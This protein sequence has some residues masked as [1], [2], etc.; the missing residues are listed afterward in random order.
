MFNSE[1]YAG[2]R[3]AIMEDI[4]RHNRVIE[5][6]RLSTSKACIKRFKASTK[7]LTRLYSQLQAINKAELQDAELWR[8]TTF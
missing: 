2:R 8:S 6:L 7:A 5:S 3:A 1:F 4:A